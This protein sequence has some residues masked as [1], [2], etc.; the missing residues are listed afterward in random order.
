MAELLLELLS[1]EIPARMQ[2]RAAADLKRLVG[3]ALKKDGFNFSSIETYSTPRRL[4]L[5]VNDLPTETPNIKEEKKGPRT[6]APDKA[7][8]GFCTANSVSKLD[9]QI[10]STEKGEFYFAVIEKAGLSTAEHVPL[11]VELAAFNLSWPK[12][13]RWGNASYTWVRPLHSILVMFDGKPVMGSI[14]RGTSYKIAGLNV[15]S[16]LVPDE[17]TF[18][19]TSKTVGHRFMAPDE[20]TVSGFADYRD[21]LRTAYVMLDS[22]ER[23]SVIEQDAALAAEAEGLTLKPDA[24]LIAE[25][26]GL[27]EWPVVLIGAIDPEF[28][29]LPAEV[30]TT[31]MRHHLKHFAL[32]DADG[33]LAPRFAVVANIHAVDGGKQIVAGN[34]RVL[35]ARLADAKFFWDQDVKR[36]LESCIPDLDA[37]VFHA[38][39][40]SV[41]EK[42]T[43]I[44]ALAV[45]IAKSIEGADEAEVREAARL[46][47]SDLVTGMVGEFPELQGVMG[48]YYALAEG[49]CEAVAT[50]IAEHYAPQGPND[51]CPTAPAS[52]AVALADKIDS[53]VGFWAIDEKPT[54]SKDPFALRRAALGVIRLIVENGLRLPLNNL[55]GDDVATDLLGFF[56]DRLK[57]HLKERGVRHDLIAA[58]FALGDED[59][60]V[61]L[62][63]RVE[64][65]QDFIASEDGEHLLTAYRR[66]A[67]IVRIEEKK[68]GV[69]YDGGAIDQGLLQEDDER[70]LAVRLSEVT[71]LASAARDHEEYAT[72]MSALAELRKPVD[73]FFDRVTVNVEDKE[74]RINRLNLLSEIRVELDLVADFSKIEG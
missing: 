3:E 13:M 29:G 8:Q 40:G 25:V 59:D 6:D 27:V 67:N 48:R 42:V 21:K 20:I 4:V 30:L 37:L 5:V 32:L 70:A 35:R 36:S 11:I 39:L 15:G 68:D 19:F 53:L 7:V 9:L 17:K 31:A 45:E 14:Q 24:G 16:P 28:M 23:R 58:V 22:A 12:S 62:L 18:D 1:E 69:R 50:A 60:L 65:L 71:K 47:K 72:A 38:K 49:K 26:A 34:E 73:D 56:A 46:C 2:D 10:R 41:G 57:V 51:P 61:R 55:F 52:V 44:E 66:A 54:G 33:N 64:A 74:L 43:R 63:A